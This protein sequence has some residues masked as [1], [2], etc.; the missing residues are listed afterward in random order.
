M[1]AK[2]DDPLGGKPCFQGRTAKF[3]VGVSNLYSLE[4][5][6]GKTICKE[7]RRSAGCPKLD[8]T[9]N[10]EWFFLLLFPWDPWGIMG[11]LYIYPHEWLIFYGKSM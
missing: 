6:W 9:S 2:E 5:V 8:P 1:M 3:A 10:F 7:I 4:R 11:R